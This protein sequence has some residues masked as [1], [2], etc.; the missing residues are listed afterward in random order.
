L[1]WKEEVNGKNWDLKKKR[2]WR[3]GKQIDG[4]TAIKGRE[5]SKF[6]REPEREDRETGEMSE[7]AVKG[8][9]PQ[10]SEISG[11]Y[12][13]KNRNQRPRRRY[14]NPSITGGGAKTERSTAPRGGKEMAY[15]D[16]FIYRQTG[17]SAIPVWGE[18][19]QK[20]TDSG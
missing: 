11:E 14:P 16:L 15:P 18:D 4:E 17:I 9:N 20:G 3:H 7:S 6:Q 19:P 8:E 12:A 10:K 13:L 1:P 2:V 5:R